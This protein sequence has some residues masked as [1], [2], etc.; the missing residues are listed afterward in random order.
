MLPQDIQS[1]YNFYIAGKSLW[2]DDSAAM[3]SAKHSPGVHFLGYIS[4]EEKYAY[5]KEAKA[6]I[7]PSV[8]EGF[9]LPLLEAMAMGIP[10]ITSNV[11]SMPEVVGDAGILIDPHDVSTIAQA[12]KSLVTDSQLHN[13]YRLRGQERV[14]QFTWEKTAQETYALFNRLIN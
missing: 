12:M 7:Y 9:G 10:V 14:Q 3:K 11:S 6:F 1:E 13:V 5:L 2:K 8:Y 4:D